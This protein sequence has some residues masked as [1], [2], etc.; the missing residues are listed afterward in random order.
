MHLVFVADIDPGPVMDFLGPETVHGEGMKPPMERQDSRN[1]DLQESLRDSSG[2]SCDLG[3]T[4]CIE[5]DI[6]SQ[7]T[8]VAI[9][10]ESVRSG[11]LC[12]LNLPVQGRL[13][14]VGELHW[15]G[16]AHSRG[17]VWD[18]GGVGTPRLI[19]CCDCLCLIA[20]F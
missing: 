10:D 4:C 13:P 14:V 2:L 9:S 7:N 11:M 15:M 3:V 6:W 17:A 20:L 18:P 19:V 12:L 16:M 1:N 8:A 5:P